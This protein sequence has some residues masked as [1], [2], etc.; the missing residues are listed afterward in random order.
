MWSAKCRLSY[1]PD[2]QARGCHLPSKFQTK[3]GH[4]GHR[5]NNVITKCQVG[6]GMATHGQIDVC[7][8]VGRWLL[9]CS[10]ESVDHFATSVRQVFNH[11]QSLRTLG[12]YLMPST[13][14]QTAH[15]LLLTCTT[16]L[17]PAGCSGL[18]KAGVRRFSD[19]QIQ[20]PPCSHC[21]CP[22]A[23]CSIPPL[24]GHWVLDSLTPTRLSDP[25][26]LQSQHT[27]INNHCGTKAHHWLSVEAIHS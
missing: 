17:S 7:S 24:P 8:W 4:R 11:Q 26:P 18:Y 10:V 13:V 2:S 20:W 14:L 22:R 6:H 21:M 3:M 19:P 27:C 16:T 15:T 5:S 12:S 23:Q 1:K 9:K 25:R